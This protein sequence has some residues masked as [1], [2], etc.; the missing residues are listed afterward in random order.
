MLASFARTN[1]DGNGYSTHVAGIIGSASYDVAKATTIFGVKVFDNSGFGTYIAVITGMDFVT[2]NY[3]NRECLN[4]IFV[5]MSRGG[6]FSVTANAAAVNM[7]TKSVFL[8]VAAG[9][10]YNDA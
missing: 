8:A 5:N 2:S 4:G 10:D 3:T 1:T 7:V 6:S 9:N